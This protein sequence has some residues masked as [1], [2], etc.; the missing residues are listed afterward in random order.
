[1]QISTTT[2]ENSMEISQKLEIK[3]SYD[4]VILILGISPMKCKT[5]NSGDTCTSMFT[6]ALL[7]IA[8][9]LKQPGC[10]TADE[11][12]KKCSTYTQWTITQPKG[13]LVCGLKV[14]GC[15]WRTSC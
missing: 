1:M 11:W 2:L 4:P 8:K 7:T 3:L 14:N 12:I 10:P 5:G 13:I 15:N 6:A 9:L